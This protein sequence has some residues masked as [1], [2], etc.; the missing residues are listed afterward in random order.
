MGKTTLLKHLAARHL[1]VPE[2]WTVTLVQQEAE[3]TDVPVSASCVSHIGSP[4]RLG[5]PLTRHTH[6]STMQTPSKKY[7]EVVD[8]VIR[9]DRRRRLLLQREAI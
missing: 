9:A 4:S 6:A 5:R 2:H 8:E 7:P 3:A 1:P